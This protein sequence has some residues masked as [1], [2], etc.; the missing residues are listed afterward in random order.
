[1]KRA[2]LAAIVLLHATESLALI[3]ESDAYDQALAQAGRAAAQRIVTDRNQLIQSII[4]EG[5][6]GC[7]NQ[8]TNGASTATQS[9]GRFQRRSQYMSGEYS[10][11]CDEM[12]WGLDCHYD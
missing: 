11:E 4:S 12:K 10:R 1:M 3:G 8:I 6:Y 7:L 5:Y 2:V 9:N